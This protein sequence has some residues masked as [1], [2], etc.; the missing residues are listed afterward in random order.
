MVLQNILVYKYQLNLFIATQIFLHFVEEYCKAYHKTL[1][2]LLLTHILHKYSDTHVHVL[3]Y[4]HMSAKPE[5]WLIYP[6]THTCQ[7]SLSIG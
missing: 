2:L 6:V 3:S 5:Y 4:P 7:L 1:S